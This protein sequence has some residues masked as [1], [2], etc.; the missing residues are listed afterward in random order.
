M[1]KESNDKERKKAGVRREKQP[2]GENGTV[3]LETRDQRLE[4]RD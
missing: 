4:T 3:R 1:R 2:D